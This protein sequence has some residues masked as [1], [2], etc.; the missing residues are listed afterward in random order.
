MTARARGGPW[1][2]DGSGGDAP[3]REGRREIDM[4][5]EQRLQSEA[6]GP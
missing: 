1:G 6:Q 4:N 2:L 5:A 3:V